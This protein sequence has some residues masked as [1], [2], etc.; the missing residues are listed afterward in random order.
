M[1]FPRPNR[2]NKKLFLGLRGIRAGCRVEW[3]GLLRRRR[4]K[5][6]SG[7]G[8]PTGADGEWLCRAGFRDGI[9]LLDWSS[10]H[11]LRQCGLLLFSLLGRQQDKL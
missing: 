8:V 1:H 3:G 5:V 4:E 7:C 2:K 6:L 10:G 9:G 11:Q